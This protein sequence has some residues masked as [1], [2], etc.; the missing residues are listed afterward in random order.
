MYSISGTSFNIAFN[1]S[2]SPAPIPEQT[3]TFCKRNINK[4]EKMFS[5]TIVSYNMQQL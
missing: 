3:D 1:F 5:E 2:S 4:A